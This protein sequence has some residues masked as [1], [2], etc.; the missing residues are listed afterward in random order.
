MREDSDFIFL[1]RK[2]GPLGASLNNSGQG[3]GSKTVAVSA[4]GHNC[5]GQ[6]RTVHVQVILVALALLAF[7][8][9]FLLGFWGI[10]FRTNL[11]SSH[12]PSSEA[13]ELALC[14]RSNLM[15]R[16]CLVCRQWGVWS[17]GFVMTSATWSAVQMYLTLSFLS[18][19]LC[20]LMGSVAVSMCFVAA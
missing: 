17:N 15:P 19:I 1:K 7:S 14:E 5:L 16:T 13:L 20:C 6:N 3:G 18:S 9:E 10:F 12:P 4:H 8:P 11:P 2:L